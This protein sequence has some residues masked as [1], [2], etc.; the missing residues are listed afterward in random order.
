[1]DVGGRAM[2]GTIAEKR[3]LELLNEDS[4]TFLPTVGA[5]GDEYEDKKSFVKCYLGHG[6]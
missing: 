3:N 1:M 2:S 4:S 5:L 6:I